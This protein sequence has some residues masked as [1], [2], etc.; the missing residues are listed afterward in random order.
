MGENPP[1]G[2]IIEY[3]LQSGASD[4][5]M[6]ICDAAGK[7]I[8]HYSS[9]DTLYQVPEVNIPLYWIR[10]QN[11]LSAAA[12]AHR[13]LWDMHYTPLNVPPTYP[14]GAIYEDTP[15]APTSPW[16]MP[17]TYTVKLTVNGNVY[18]QPLKV[19]MD[20]RVKTSA[21]DLQKQHDLTYQCYTDVLKCIELAERF[22]AG[23]NDKQ[24]EAIRS[25]ERVLRGEHDRMQGADVAPTTQSIQAVREAH[26][27]LYELQA[28]ENKR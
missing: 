22:K 26:T 19:V 17:G 1:D 8:R 12:G 15:P 7:V 13:F 6:D 18:T 16:V 23:G 14:I 10:P 21:R 27:K 28:L 24:A 25:V 2:A 9:K 3:Y 20:P 5:T 11:T 4:A